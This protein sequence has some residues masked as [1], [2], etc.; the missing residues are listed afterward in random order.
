MRVMRDEHKQAYLAS[1]NVGESG[2]V[3]EYRLDE[4]LRARRLEKDLKISPN[5]QQPR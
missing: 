1:L 4:R 3:I 2:R 5:P